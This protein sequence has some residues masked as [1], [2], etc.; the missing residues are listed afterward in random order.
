MAKLLGTD[1][2]NKVRRRIRMSVCMAVKTDDA[3][4]WTFGPAVFGLVELLL[5]K[6]GQ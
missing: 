3:S 2:S 5:W 6:R 4:A 1:I